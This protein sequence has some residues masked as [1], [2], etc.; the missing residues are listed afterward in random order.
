MMKWSEVSQNQF[1]R[2]VYWQKSWKYGSSSKALAVLVWTLWKLERGETWL[3][4]NR[5]PEICRLQGR[6]AKQSSSSQQT[7]KQTSKQAN[8]QTNKQTNKHENTLFPQMAGSSEAHVILICEA[9]SL[10]SYEK[11]LA[12]FG[13]TLCLNNAENLLLPSWTW[14]RRQYPTDCRSQGRWSIKQLPRTKEE[15]LL[16]NL[17]DQV[18]GCHIKEKRAASCKGYF[19]S[20]E[21]QNLETMARARMAATRSCVCFVS[22]EDAGKWHAIT[23]ECLAT[24]LYKC[25]VHQVASI[26][27]ANQMAHQRQGRP[28]IQ[29]FVARRA[30]H[31]ASYVH[32]KFSK[33]QLGEKV[34][35]EEEIRK[36]TTNIGDCCTL[37]F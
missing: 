27:D 3:P 13:W 11:Y 26:G 20:Q 37:P 15:R 2:R 32:L 22:N 17:W 24:M 30:F 36:K 7:N 33:E 12:E 34:D 28:A 16:C 10:K 21:P 8:K 31:I 25:F 1:G 19:S 14:G 5:R 35:V 18:G 29:L 6:P 4:F 9:G 23:G